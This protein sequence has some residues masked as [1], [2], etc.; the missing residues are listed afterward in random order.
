MRDFAKSEQVS[1]RRDLV[2][3]ETEP[4][5]DFGVEGASA[6]N[7]SRTEI[8]ARRRAG[9]PR[10]GARAAAIAS[11]MV[12]FPLAFGPTSKVKSRTRPKASVKSNTIGCEVVPRCR[13]FSRLILANFKGSSSRTAIVVAAMPPRPVIVTTGAGSRHHA[14]DIDGRGVRTTA[15]CQATIIFPFRV[16]STRNVTEPRRGWQIAFTAVFAAVSSHVDSC[17]Y[18]FCLD[19]GNL[20]PNPATQVERGGIEALLGGGC[21]EVQTDCLPTRIGSSGRPPC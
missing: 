17:L 9:V 7:R 1:T 20:T 11:R 8:E 13:K 15:N 18:S 4:A 2:G 21:V 5:C 19:P 10:P 3:A 14:A 6:N 16:A 12:V